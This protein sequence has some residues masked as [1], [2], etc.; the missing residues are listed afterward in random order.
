[1]KL[2]QKLDHFVLGWRS[3]AET[4]VGYFPQLADRAA[5]IHQRDDEAGRRRETVDAARSGVLQQVPHLAAVAMPVQASMGPQLGP[6]IGDPI[7]EA[8][9]KRFGHDR[10]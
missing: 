3:L 7:P 4:A 5:A 2:A 8:A 6:E 10:F 1:M 9:Q